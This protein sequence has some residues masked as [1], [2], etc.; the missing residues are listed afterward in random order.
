MNKENYLIHT[1]V[2]IIAGFEV[3]YQVKYFITVNHKG[4]GRKTN[5]MLT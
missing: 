4:I 5:N 1:I 2:T 3:T